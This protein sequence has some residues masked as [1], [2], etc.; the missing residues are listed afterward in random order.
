MAST[1]DDAGPA[2][3]A[4]DAISSV[5]L[6]HWP[7]LML[8]QEQCDAMRTLADGLDSLVV[9]PTGFGK[10]LCF[11]APAVA[12]GG[13]TIVITPLLALAEDQ[14][15]DCQERSIE[16]ALWNSSVG[17]R[18]KA[19]MRADL[20]SDE[21]ET[22]LLYVTPEGLQNGPLPEL[23]RGLHARGLLRAFVVDEAH[24]V[25]QWGHSFRREYLEL[26][27]VRRRLAPGVPM[28]A[29]T[30]TA[31]GAVCKE[32]VKALLREAGGIR[33]HTSGPV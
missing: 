24:C 17:E 12:S 27:A 25:S 26:G 14:V 1:S 9:L 32:V 20:E 2:A 18:D 13:V 22:R 28:M 11:Q 19:M 8:R 29:L 21:P 30:A 33:A 6:A 7:T 5:L 10:S 31:T 15:N 4:S 3:V 23:V 16:A